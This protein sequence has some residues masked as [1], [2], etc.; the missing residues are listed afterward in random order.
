MYCSNAFYVC[1]LSFWKDRYFQGKGVT[2]RGRGGGVT[3]RGRGGRYFQ[4]K[5]GGALL[6][7]FDRKLTLLSGSRYFR[8]DR[9]FWNST[10]QNVG[11]EKFN[12]RS[13]KLSKDFTFIR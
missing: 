2:F 4:G 5:G 13:S 11:P 9:Y 12:P 3:F 6:S 1:E 8:G 7:G 10:V